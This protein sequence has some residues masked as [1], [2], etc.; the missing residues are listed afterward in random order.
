MQENV[1]AN[2]EWGRVSKELEVT[3]VLIDAFMLWFFLLGRF[4]FRDHRMA[5]IGKKYTA[6]L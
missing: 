4:A 3:K 2:A 1:E 6:I 5:W